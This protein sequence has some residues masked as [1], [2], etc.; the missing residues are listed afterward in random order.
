MEERSVLVFT[1]EEEEFVNLLI[2]IGTRRSVAQTLVFLVNT[3][4]ATSR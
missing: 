2:K 3:P 1:E 4:E